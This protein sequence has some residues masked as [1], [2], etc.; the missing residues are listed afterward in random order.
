MHRVPQIK[1]KTLQLNALKADDK[2]THAKCWLDHASQRTPPNKH[3]EQSMSRERLENGEN[4][5]P[6][7]GCEGCPLL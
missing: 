1:K 5:S 4:Q 7:I 2:I 6:H 3:S